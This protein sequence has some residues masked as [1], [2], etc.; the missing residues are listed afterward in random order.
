MKKLVILLVILLGVGYL[1]F[2]STDPNATDTLGLWKPDADDRSAALADANN[3]WELID[4]VFTGNATNAYPYF[5]YTSAAIGE[6]GADAYGLK[7]KASTT[8]NNAT[9]YTFKGINIEA[10]LG[11]GGEVTNLIGGSIT[12]H[13]RIGSVEPGA[14]N[15]YGLQVEAKAN[16]GVTALM[17]PLD[18]RHYRQAASH[19]T[20]EVIARLRNESTTGTGVDAGLRI[21]SSGS[22][23]TD[24]FVNGIDLASADIDQ[25]QIVLSNSAKIFTGTANG[26]NAVYT[27][28]GAYDG[29]GSVYFSTV[30][31]IYI[32]VA[33]AGAN[34]DWETVT[35][36]SAE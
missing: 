29:I 14:A 33:N 5:S 35:S 30:G 31:K 27:E 1:A 22:G 11:T 32:Q 23:G 36:A 25:A 18:V 12:G 26:E 3:N 20:V 28:V 6:A 9:G 17:I 24:D 19:P 8:A 13:T 7:V 2:A 34:T 16:T 21:E 15:L 10:R 4:N